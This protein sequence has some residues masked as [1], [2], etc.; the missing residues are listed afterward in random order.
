MDGVQRLYAFTAFGGMAHAGRIYVKIGIPTSV[1]IAQVK[2]LLI[3]NPILLVL[4]GLRPL[5]EVIC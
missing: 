4:A 1:A 3:R 5:D 2:G